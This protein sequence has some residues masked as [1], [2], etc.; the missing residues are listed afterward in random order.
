MLSTFFILTFNN[1]NN[2]LNKKY[3]FKRPRFTET[4]GLFR[5]FNFN[6]NALSISNYYENT[7]VK[8]L[9]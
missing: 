4:Y 3:Y 5:K 2:Y 8:Y 1:N 9:D 7:L 6:L